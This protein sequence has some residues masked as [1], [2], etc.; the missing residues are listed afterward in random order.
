MQLWSRSGGG[1]SSADGRSAVS[2]RGDAPMRLDGVCG[3]GDEVVLWG[4][5]SQDLSPC[6]RPQGG[7]PSAGAMSGGTARRILVACLAASSWSMTGCAAWLIGGFWRDVKTGAVS[8]MRNQISWHLPI[9]SIWLD[10]SSC[11]T[12]WR[13]AGLVASRRLV[14]QSRPWQK[15]QL[16]TDKVFFLKKGS[17]ASSNTATKRQSSCA[18]EAGLLCG[19]MLAGW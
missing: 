11:S 6:H 7:C 17:E 13:V 16:E 5:E 19:Y 12:P 1:R 8:W 3:S 14:V 9:A 18:R 2:G 10:V 4:I 15:G